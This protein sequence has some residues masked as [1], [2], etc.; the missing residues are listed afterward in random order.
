L[1]RRLI[2]EWSGLD[3]AVLI[4]AYRHLVR[5]H[6]VG[7]AGK[8]AT[9]ELDQE[10]PGQGLFAATLTRA[11]QYAFALDRAS[12]MLEAELELNGELRPDVREALKRVLD[13]LVLR[14][15]LDPPTGAA[16][17]RAQARP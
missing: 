16:I 7:S 12:D 11:G 14:G 1:I 6:L 10:Y 17:A 13:E 5:A 2:D 9:A 8:A 3:R 4:D 15:A